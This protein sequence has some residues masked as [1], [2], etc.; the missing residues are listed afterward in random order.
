MKAAPS[1]L[2]LKAKRKY[3]NPKHSYE[4]LFEGPAHNLVRNRSMFGVEDSLSV[5]SKAIDSKDSLK[6]NSSK[7][8]LDL[9]GRKDSLPN[10]CDRRF[11]SINLDPKI[12]S[13]VRHQR[14][15]DLF[16]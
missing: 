4:I 5:V 2:S 6:K 8:R 16:K 15:V 3:L 12:S 7:A 13:K 9:V 11:D 1:Y 14:S 10:L